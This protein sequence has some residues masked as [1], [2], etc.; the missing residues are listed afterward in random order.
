MR[1]CSS[2]FFKNLSLRSAIN[3]IVNGVANLVPIAVTRN[4]IEVFPLKLKMLFRQ[5]FFIF[6]L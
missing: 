4:Y 2:M 3:R 1:G 6:N 5:D